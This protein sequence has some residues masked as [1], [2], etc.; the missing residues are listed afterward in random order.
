MAVCQEWD[1]E[2]FNFLID[3]NRFIQRAFKQYILPS[4]NWYAMGNGEI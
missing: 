3:E 2:D 1:K 4:K